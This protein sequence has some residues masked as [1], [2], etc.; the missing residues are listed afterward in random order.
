MGSEPIFIRSIPK[1]DHRRLWTLFWA[2]TKRGTGTWG[3]GRRDACLG[4][5]TRGREAWD[6]GTRVWGDVGT[7]GGGDAGTRERGDSGTR[8]HKIGDA[9]R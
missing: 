5:G 6:V 3:R 7:P 8:G 9:G 2:V 1:K 4:R